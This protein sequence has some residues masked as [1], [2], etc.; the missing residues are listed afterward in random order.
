MGYGDP[1]HPYHSWRMI[2]QKGRVV[3]WKCV[4]GT[5][6]TATKTTFDG[7]PQRD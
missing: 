3:K 4:S 6:C 7:K 1:K 2:S 5:T